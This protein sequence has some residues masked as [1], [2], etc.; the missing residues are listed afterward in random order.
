MSYISKISKTDQ[1]QIFAVA[2]R[3]CVTRAAD[4]RT[5]NPLE[6]REPQFGTKLCHRA[7]RSIV[8]TE[9]GRLLLDEAR[10]VVNRAEAVKLAMR[11]FTG[12][13]FGRLTCGS[14][15]LEILRAYPAS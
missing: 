13:A 12:L 2:E 15:A 9:G 4:P 3:E 7:G 10:A 14:A 1:L 11:E 6:M 8:A 5:G